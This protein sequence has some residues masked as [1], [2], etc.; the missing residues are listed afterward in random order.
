MVLRYGL[1]CPG[2]SSNENG[3][4]ALL[5]FLL[6]KAKPSAKASFAGCYPTIDSSQRRDFK[7]IAREML[8]ELK[9]D[10]VTKSHLIRSS[11][12]NTAKGKPA[13]VL[14][15]AFSHDLLCNV[16]DKV[17]GH[18][19][20]DRTDLQSIARAIDG[21]GET[22]ADVLA[23]LR[24]EKEKELAALHHVLEQVSRDRKDLDSFLE[25]L[26]HQNACIDEESKSLDSLIA[27]EEALLA[28]ESEQL[29]V[30]ELDKAVEGMRNDVKGLNKK[31]GKT[32][33]Q[34]ASMTTA[35]ENQIAPLV[36]DASE[37]PS[38]LQSWSKTSFA[39]SCELTRTLRDLG[40]ESSELDHLRRI[41]Q[42]N[43]ELQDGLELK[44]S[45]LQ[46]SIKRFHLR[47][48]TQINCLN[49]KVKMTELGVRRVTPSLTTTPASNDLHG[50]VDR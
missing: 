35:H 7:R 40:W 49:E 27:E 28:K 5:Y 37:I 11:T 46:D 26:A 9:R 6:L 14:V 4:L 33:E 22:V 18:T 20:C 2:S 47:T 29:D 17:E 15:W 13:Q 16:I 30:D 39:L 38:I 8:E 10:G 24:E 50:R 41:A 48:A 36:S 23:K 12:L 19:D 42:R 3:L 25:G 32:L 21:V 1:G 34:I 45:E 43:N 44:Y 31:L